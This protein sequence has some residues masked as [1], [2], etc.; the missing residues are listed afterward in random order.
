MFL[1]KLTKDKGVVH[2][3]QLIQH[4]KMPYKFSFVDYS[5]I[6]NHMT[7]ETFLVT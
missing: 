4:K 7:C 1:E 6:H 5:D 3:F 2:S